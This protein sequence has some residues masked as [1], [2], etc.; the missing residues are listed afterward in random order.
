MRTYRLLKSRFSSRALTVIE[1]MV[2]LMVTLILA[3]TAI[4]FLQAYV[5]RSRTA[6]AFLALGKMAD[7]Q[8]AH[9]VKNGA[10]IE[11]GPSNIPPAGDPTSVSFT[12]AWNAIDFNIIEPVRFGYRCYED[13]GPEDFICEAQGDQDR[14]GNVSIIQMRVSVVDGRPQKAAGFVVFDELE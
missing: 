5:Y 2:A 11:T 12:G 6:E 7:G 9:F 10:F 8:A 3:S 14:D 13:T 4:E 1:L